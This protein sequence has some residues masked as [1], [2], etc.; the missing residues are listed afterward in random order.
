MKRH[1]P[2]FI[3][4]CNVMCGSAA[5]IAILYGAIG[6]AAILILCG[7]IFDFFDGLT[8][9]ALHVKSEMGKELDSLADVVSFG[10]APAMIAHMLIKFSIFG[11][12]EANISEATVGE[13]VML[14]SPVLLTAFSAYRLAKFNLDTRQTVSFIGM[15]TPANALFW[16]SLVFGF[17]FYPEMYLLLFNNPIELTCIM[18]FLSIMLVSELPMFSLKLS[19]L[20]FRQNKTQYIY[21]ICLAILFAIFWGFA[22][23]W[24]IPLYLL[25]S[26]IAAMVCR[27]KS[28]N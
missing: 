2:N 10:A 5:I 19:G 11:D 21:F 12:F 6:A 9:R 24:I 13:W 1:I 8:A 14:F 4:S 18:I 28:N 20:G 27:K 7:M 16:L 22:I 3:T 26:I 23:I 17:Y 15:P 25:V